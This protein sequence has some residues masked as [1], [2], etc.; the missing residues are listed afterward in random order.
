MRYPAQNG[1]ATIQLP[2]GSGTIMGKGTE[3]LQ[4][5]EDQESAVRPV[6][7]YLLETTEKLHTIPQA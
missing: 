4:G 2:I 3:G 1:T 6:R 5:Q 7:P